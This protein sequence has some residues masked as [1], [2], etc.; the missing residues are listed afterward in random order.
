L[1]SIAP[2]ES[3]LDRIQPDLAVGN[4]SRPRWGRK[5]QGRRSGAGAASRRICM[6]GSNGKQVD[7]TARDCRGSDP[8][9]LAQ[10]WTFVTF[11]SQ[12]LPPPPHLPLWR[13]P[14]PH[15]VSARGL[16]VRSSRHDGVRRRIARGAPRSRA[17][18][19]LV[20]PLAAATTA[21]H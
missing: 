15:P 2:N 19:R 6:V 8:F 18:L 5:E 17:A 10:V 1:S 4:R 3:I 16:P 11:L 21:V 9:D 12:P 20:A 14:R 13:N 7:C